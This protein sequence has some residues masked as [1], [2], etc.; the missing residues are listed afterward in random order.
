[1]RVLVDTSVWSLALRRSRESLGPSDARA[2]DKLAELVRE[3]LVVMI[4][5]IRQELL[6]GVPDEGR[7]GELRDKLR[8]FED[9]ATASDD[10]ELAAAF[11]NAC[12]KKGVQGSHTDFLICAVAARNKLLVFTLDR[13][14]ERFAKSLNIALFTLRS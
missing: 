4:G 10:H 11:F 13:D 8:A 6:S 7:F 9:L 12:R 14:F 1:M 3:G 5:P 2:V